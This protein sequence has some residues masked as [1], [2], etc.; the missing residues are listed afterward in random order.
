MEPSPVGLNASVVPWLTDRPV[1]KTC[2][3][4]RK[5]KQFLRCA[6]DDNFLFELDFSELDFWRANWMG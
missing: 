1:R 4:Y 5:Q 2:S 3:R 6:Q